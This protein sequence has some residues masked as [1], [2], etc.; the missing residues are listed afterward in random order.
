MENSAH[1]IELTTIG[2]FFGA[3]ANH[4]TGITQFNDNH[5]LDTAFGGTKQ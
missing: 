2:Q 5:E 1:S 4:L 3:D